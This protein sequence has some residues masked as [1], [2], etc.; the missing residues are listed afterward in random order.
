MTQEKE[1]SNEQQTIYEG[2]DN[3]LEL[4]LE[5]E[6]ILNNY[7]ITFVKEKYCGGVV[8]NNTDS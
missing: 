5:R 1:K 8:N 2:K 7:S 3:E 6:N 4:Y